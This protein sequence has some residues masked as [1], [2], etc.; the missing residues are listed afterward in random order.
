MGSI[1]YNY[2]EFVPRGNNILSPYQGEAPYT[3]YF[4][5]ND[6][7]L[8]KLNEGLSWSIQAQQAIY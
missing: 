2:K 6:L 8:V 3:P 1:S 4:Q 5:Q 7:G